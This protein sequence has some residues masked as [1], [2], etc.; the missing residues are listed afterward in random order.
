MSGGTY[1]VGDTARVTFQVIDPA[2]G[3]PADATT[4]TWTISEPVALGPTAAVHY[5]P[6]GSGTYYASVPLT[7]AGVWR[8]EF[9]ATPIGG[10]EPFVLVVAA[11]STLLPW[12]PT[13]TQVADYVPGR[14]RPASVGAVDAPLG[15]FTADTV[16]TGEQVARLAAAA[17]AHVAAAVGTV[18]PSLYVLASAAAAQRAA[19]Y[20]EYA[21]PERD[22][23]VNTGDVLL[24]LADA[25]L[26]R[27]ASA[28]LAVSGTTVGAAAVPYW[29]FPDATVHGDLDL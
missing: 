12:A 6:V 10:D 19:A 11:D 21:Y 17:A 9:K 13:L 8:G 5:G 25:T 2:T 22:A 14:T 28:N 24:A 1:D 3:L 7:A 15:T 18:D 23:D 4:V 26:D 29:S 27:V 20:V 16:P